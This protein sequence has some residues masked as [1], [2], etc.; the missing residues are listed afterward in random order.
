LR[1]PEDLFDALSRSRFRTK[2]SLGAEERS[3][4]H[5][6]GRTAV[7]EHASDFIGRRLAPAYPVRDGKQTPM[8]GH[9]VFVAQHAT[10]TC[11]RGCLEKWHG[12]PPAVRRGAGVRRRGHRPLAA[13]PGSIGAGNRRAHL[14]RLMVAAALLLLLLGAMRANAQATPPG[15]P[16]RV[17][18]DCGFCDDDYLQVETPWV[19]FVR[20]RGASDVH[21]LLTRIETGGGGQRYQLAVLPRDSAGRRDTLTFVTGPTASED[22]RRAEITRNVQLALVPYAMRTAAKAVLRV[23]SMRPGGPAAQPAET[24]RDPWRAW[25]FEVGG[26]ASVQNEQRQSDANFEGSIEGRRVTAGLKLGFESSAESRW[27]RFQ[28][29]DD[30]DV[31]G[32]VVSRSERYDAGIVAVRSLGRHWA[33]GGEAAV[34]SSTFSNTKLAVRAAPA[35]EYSLWPYAQ[36]IRRQLVF[37]YSVGLSSYAYRETTIFDRL[38]EIRPNHTLVIGYDVRQ[39]W[40]SANASLEAASYLDDAQQNRIEADAEWSVRLFQ[41]LSLDLEASA[42]RIRDQLS[43]PKRDATPEE[44]LLQR[45]ALGTDYRYELRAGFS[46]TFG[47]IFSAVVNPRFGSGP[48]DILR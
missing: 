36:A 17:F 15:E 21:L 38:R 4:L 33:V 5:M 47:S 44:I 31:G 28:L 34:N 27:S 6:K 45:R 3:Y 12:I 48:G 18:L 20:D 13:P 41:G 14:V 30:D 22:G 43:L 25:V 1:K 46:Y 8:R 7:R 26:S 29:D 11:C 24:A 32:S 39:P 35:V 37:Q 42:E 2:F 10:A 16:V 40:G 23:I 9:P 19:S